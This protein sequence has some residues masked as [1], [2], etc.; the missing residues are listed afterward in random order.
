MVRLP[1]RIIL[2]PKPVVGDVLPLA[3]SFDRI[4]PGYLRYLTTAS[5]LKRQCNFISL[6]LL[7]EHGPEFVASHFRAAGLIEN[8]SSLDPAAQVARALIMRRAADII[9]TACIFGSASSTAL[10]VLHRIGDEP[11]SRSGYRALIDLMSDPQHRARAQSF[12]QECPVTET[13]LQAALKLPIPLVRTEILTRLKSVEQIDELSAAFDLIFP[14]LP[15]EAQASAWQSLSSLQSTASLKAW[16]RRLVEKVPKYPVSGPLSDDAETMLLSSPQMMADTGRR[17]KNCLATLV[18]QPLLSRYVYYLW[19][20]PS[21]VIELRCLSQG[22]FVLKSVHTTGHETVDAATMM[23]I[24]DKFERTGKVLV[25]AECAEATK[26]NRAAKLLDVWTRGLPD[27]DD[28]EIID[29]F[30]LEDAA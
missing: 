30:N 21:A 15:E 7:D 19:C 27:F 26:A 16:L 20:N 11:L 10:R 29:L 5:A 8:C 24:R 3:L 9:Q 17:L 18:V 12:G 22:F 14:L 1:D 2:K 13:S 25:G 28:D 6:S 4:H 23:Q